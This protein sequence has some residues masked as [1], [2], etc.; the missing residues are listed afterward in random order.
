[1]LQASYDTILVLLSLF[2]A[3]L[4][5]YTTLDL[6]QRIARLADQRY[7]RLWLLGGAVSMGIGIWSMHFVGMLA[8]SLSIPLG[9]DTLITAISLVIAISVS[10]FALYLV[11]GATLSWRRLVAGGTVMGAGIAAMHYTGMAALRMFPAID[12]DPLRFSLSIVIA[13]VAS[14]AA[15][16][17]AFNLRSEKLTYLLARR[18]G[19]ALVMGL[20]ITGM[21]YT[22]MWA[23]SF[24]G[25]SVCIA[26]TGIDQK[27]LAA[28]ILLGSVGVLGLTLVLSLFDARME[29]SDAR[30]KR[31]LEAANEELQYR[32]THDALTG[33]PNRMML[34]ERLQYVIDAYERNGKRFAVYFMDLDGFKAINDALG[35]RV[36]DALLK[37]LARRLRQRVRKQDLVARFGGDEFVI[38]VE[39]VADAAMAASLAGKIFDCFIEEF[40]LQD[41]GMSVSPSVGIALYPENGDSIETLLKNADAAMYEAKAHGRNN[42]RFFESAMNVS[43]QRT[44]QIQRGLRTAA[45]ANQF[46]LDFQPKFGCKHGHLIGLEALLRWRHP[47]LGL[48][49]PAEFIPIAE[50]AGQIVRLGRW[51]VEETCRQM[52]EWDAAGALPVKVAVN[53]SPNQLSTP[54]LAEEMAAVL[55]KYAIPPTRMMFEITETV[56]MRDTEASIAAIGKLHGLGFDLSIDDFG[57]GYSSLAYLQ[58]FA[59]GQLK[60]DRSFVSALDSDDPKSLTIVSAIIGLAHALGMEVVAEGVE[61]Q[62]QLALLNAMKCDQVQ[63]YLLARPL[64]AERIKE[65]LVEMSEERAAA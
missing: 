10:Y 26:A 20:A 45:A 41:S 64:A 36:G 18:L 39:D 51:V 59:A 4:A 25:E 6:S 55:K 50:R 46:Y 29:L 54:C 27:W 61:T 9:Y 17:I 60:V 12:Y 63:G 21:H 15:L 62:E 37:E 2:I 34:G 13:V 33:L 52:R 24:A 31:S 48:I 8:L 44:M 49:S 16:W 32:A 40:D 42:Y 57:T 35:H 28:L 38:V 7:R 53:L 23:A 5:S 47:E 58:R 22:G 3:T 14:I 56:V 43:A 1:M 30:H 19:A 11:T 65:M